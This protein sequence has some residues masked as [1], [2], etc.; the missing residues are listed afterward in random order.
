MS[1]F[2]LKAP[3]GPAYF[4]EHCYQEVAQVHDLITIVQLPETASQLEMAFQFTLL[5]SFETEEEANKCKLEYLFP[6][7]YFNFNEEM[8]HDP[9]IEPTIDNEREVKPLVHRS[10]RKGW[11][12]ENIDQNEN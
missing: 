11:Q 8:I 5:G 12:K 1:Y 6:K 3:C 10:R 4:E 9:I 7:D 2:V